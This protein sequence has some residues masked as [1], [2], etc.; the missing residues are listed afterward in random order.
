MTTVATANRPL[1]Y[2]LA[3]VSWLA[4]STTTNSSRS[5]PRRWGTQFVTTVS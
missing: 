1:R 2:E 4:A 5:N 3:V